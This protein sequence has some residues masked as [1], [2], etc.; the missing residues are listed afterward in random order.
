MAAA[1]RAPTVEVYVECGAHRV[2]ACALEWPGWCRSG[3]SEEL[4]LD[5]LAA[6][7]A[8]YAAVTA[9]AE[10][11]FT[12]SPDSK[13]TVR[14]RLA[15][16]ATTDFGAPAVAPAADQEPVTRAEGMRLASC[17][18]AAWSVLD[19][20]VAT[21]PAELRKGPRGGG[22]DRDA[23]AEHVVAAE[24]AYARK[25]GL[26]G[27]RQPSARDAEAVREMRD[28]VTDKISLPWDAPT[29]PEKGWLPRYAARR[30]AWHALDH[31]WEIEDRGVL[32]SSSS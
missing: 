28:L 31:A 23:I 19:A 7:A 8:R 6:Y 20:V 29:P 4:A 22:R 25:L 9:E 26:R 18:R 10:L 21:A 30:I 3:K 24:F 13:F 2:F 12:I 5:A 32:S 17:L 27:F 1:R 14:E 11:D 15:G 16:T